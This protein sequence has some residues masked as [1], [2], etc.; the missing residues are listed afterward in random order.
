MSNYEL[1][2]LNNLADLH[3]ISVGFDNMFNRLH[4][5][6]AAGAT[7][8]PPY[9]VIKI[10]DSITKIELAVAG[11]R[12]EE[13]DVTLQNGVLSVTGVNETDPGINYL[14]RGIA[15]RKFDRSWQLA[16]GVEV[17]GA[18]VE[19]GLLVITLEHLIPEQHKP[20]KI[21]IKVK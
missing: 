6:P 2:Q 8:Y 15:T 21:A 19:Y 18:T 1:L 20:K 4:N 17:K 16:D 14:H 7:G 9:N 11:F 3:R 10:S 5:I 13:L 12:P